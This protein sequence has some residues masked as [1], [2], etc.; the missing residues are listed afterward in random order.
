[1]ARSIEEF[2]FGG[3]N[4]TYATVTHISALGNWSSVKD[5]IFEQARRS[6]IRFSQALLERAVLQN[7]LDNEYDLEGYHHTYFDQWFR[8]DTFQS[9]LEVGQEWSIL[10]R[11]NIRYN[12]EFAGDQTRVD[13]SHYSLSGL[14][15]LISLRNDVSDTTASSRLQS[16]DCDGITPEDPALTYDVISL[17]HT[18]LARF[19]S[20]IRSSYTADLKLNLWRAAELGLGDYAS[21]VAGLTHA[22]NS[23]NPPSVSDLNATQQAYNGLYGAMRE[24]NPIRQYR[25][26]TSSVAF[27]AYAP[28]NDVLIV[29]RTSYWARDAN[30]VPTALNFHS[31]LF[32]VPD[33]GTSFYT[34]CYKSGGVCTE[35]S[36][37]AGAAI[38][39]THPNINDVW[40]PLGEGAEENQFNYRTR[41]ALFSSPGLSIE[42]QPDSNGIPDFNQR[43][44]VQYGFIP[45][46]INPLYYRYD[47]LNSLAVK[48]SGSDSRYLPN[49]IVD[50]FP[51]NIGWNSAYDGICFTPDFISS[52]SC[53][54]AS[55]NFWQYSC[56]WNWV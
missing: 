10:P 52:S 15:L 29:D 20:Q 16:A 35:A 24:S 56:S 12:Q 22:N 21:H 38:F 30:G 49:Q 13:L 19:G 1:M 37:N 6:T 11:P 25:H 53:D 40:P 8:R 26:R 48:Q 2:L 43:Q 34:Y 54:R 44:T 18:S 51:T 31:K 23:A 5:T 9:Q 3:Q 14:D 47:G 7:F 50:A 39:A 46:F 55:T 28:I 42:P 33:D 36:T 17:L 32:I 45:E 41:G 27:A 4:S